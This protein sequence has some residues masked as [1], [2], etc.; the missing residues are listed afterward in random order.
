MDLCAIWLYL[1]LPDKKGDVLHHHIAAQ[2]MSAR[3][4]S[5][6]RYILAAW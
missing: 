2:S 3:A 4:A 1:Y 5:A 6:L